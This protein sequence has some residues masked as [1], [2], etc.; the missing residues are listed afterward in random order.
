MWVVNH[1]DY[2][3]C[4]LALRLC[5]SAQCVGELS[6]DSLQCLCNSAGEWLCVRGLVAVLDVEGGVLP[7]PYLVRPE[8]HQT[9]T[10]LQSHAPDV[11]LVCPSIPHIQG[12]ARAK[13]G[14]YGHRVVELMEHGVAYQQ[15]ADSDGPRLLPFPHTTNEQR[16]GE[17]TT[18]LQL[19]F[20]SGPSEARMGRKIS[21]KWS[22]MRPIRNRERPGDNCLGGV[23]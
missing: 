6:I 10:V 15:N 16:L 1:A 9:P 13:G 17:R 12:I 20:A 19:R 21:L 14:Y 22:E 7:D 2:L 4:F 11:V 3:W 8:V 5:K 23:L 18:P